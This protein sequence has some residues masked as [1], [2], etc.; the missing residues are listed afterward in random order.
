MCLRAARRPSRVCDGAWLPARSVALIAALFVSTALY[1]ADG[2]NALGLREDPVALPSLGRLIGAFLIVG[3]LAIGVAYLLK[4]FGARFLPTTLAGSAASKVSARIAI[5]R[6]T[7]LHVI[8]VEG[9]RLAVVVGRQGVAV[10]SLPGRV[11]G[12]AAAAAPSTNSS[13][14]V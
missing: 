12:D 8:E 3:A 4:H 5:D 14:V 2:G 10:H 9:A 6:T 11:G 1:A 13:R 7:M